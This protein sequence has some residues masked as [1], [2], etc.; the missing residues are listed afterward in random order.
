MKVIEQF[1]GSKTHHL[2]DCEDNIFVSEHFAAVIDGVTSKSSRRYNRETPGKACSQLLKKALDDL[3]YESTANQAVE[4][5]TSKVYSMYEELGLED[6]LINFQAE[7]A[8]ASIVVYSRLKNEIWMVGDCQCL[9]DQTYYSN[10]KPVDT[11]LSDIRSLFIHTE[12]SL[13]KSIEDI[14]TCD[15][16]R[17]FILPMLERQSIFQNSLEKNEFRYGVIDGYKVPE[18]EI[19]VFNLTDPTHIILASDGYPFIFGTLNQSEEYLKNILKNDPLCFQEFKTTKG[20][21]P[22]NLSF[23]D[24]AYLHLEI[25]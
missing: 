13:G 11:L 21:N 2:S 8:S 1:L 3:P 6:H 20:V 25:K 7:R 24:R 19:K 23:D 14:R 22:G 5:L 4:F 17:E 12:L 18:G 9:M 16:G 15:T 10:V